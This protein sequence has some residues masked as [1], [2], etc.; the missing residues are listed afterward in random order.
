LNEAVRVL[1]RA[2]AKEQ[3]R[4]AKEQRKE[5]ETELRSLPPQSLPGNLVKESFDGV[6]SAL[7]ELDSTNTKTRLHLGVLQTALGFY[8]EE[9]EAKRKEEAEQAKKKKA[10]PAKP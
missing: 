8:Q 1:N 5:G 10:A 6:R 9:L 2:Y 7:H 3:E 4:Q